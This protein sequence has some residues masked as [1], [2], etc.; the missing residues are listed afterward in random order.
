MGAW[1]TGP[2]DNDDAGDWVYALEDDGVTAVRSALDV[3]AE[4]AAEKAAAAVAA[5]AVVALAHGAPVESSEEVDEWLT[6]ADPAALEELRG[7]APAAAAALHRV[8]DGSE[9]AELYDETGDGDWRDRLTV[10]QTA[11]RR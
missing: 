2:F 11:L 8:L 9:L 4:P 6:A 7:L 1:G 10:M 5:A 3:P